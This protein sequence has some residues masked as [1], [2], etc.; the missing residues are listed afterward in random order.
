M[1]T[2]MKRTIMVGSQRISSHHV[3]ITRIRELGEARID[4]ARKARTTDEWNTLW[5]KS[6]HPYPFTS[7]NCC[8]QWMEYKVVD[9]SAEVGFF[10][11][12]MGLPIFAFDTHYAM[13]T[14]PDNAFYFGVCMVGEGDVPTPPDAIRLQ[15]VEQNIFAATI[16]LERRGIVFEVPPAPWE[17]G[18]SLHRGSFRTPNGIWVDLWGMVEGQLP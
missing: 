5:T 1:A 12:I 13:F 9:Y 18:L 6:Q 7:G 8:R 4:I 10:I 2:T 16:E 3:D 15:F 14:S 11:D 17:K